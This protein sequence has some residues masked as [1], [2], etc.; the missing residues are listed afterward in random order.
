[1]PAKGMF[2]RVVVVYTLT[3]KCPLLEMLTTLEPES[4]KETTIINININCG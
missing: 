4:K 1:M 3:D 2:Q